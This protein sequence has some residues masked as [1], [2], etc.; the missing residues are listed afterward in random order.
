MSK[1]LYWFSKGT[2]LICSSE[3]L[4]TEGFLW[5]PHFDFDLLQFDPT[6]CAALFGVF[7]LTL[8]LPKYKSDFVA[9]VSLLA[10]S[11]ILLEWKSPAPPS[12]SSWIR[13]MLQFVKLE[14]VWCTIHGSLARFNKTWG[15]FLHMLRLFQSIATLIVY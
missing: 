7:P 10:R 1:N 3:N 8:K 5:T 2:N 13:D 15:P 9:F 6:A 12:H 4:Q 11:L 14:K